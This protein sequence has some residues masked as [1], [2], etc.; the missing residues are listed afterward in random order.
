MVK[1]TLLPAAIA[2]LALSAHAGEI[3]IHQW[4]V[5][6][7]PQEVTDIPVLMDVGFFVEIKNQDKLRIKLQQVTIRD[8]EGCTEMVVNTNFNLTLSCSIYPTGAVSGDY[9][10]TVNPANLDAPGGTTIVCAQLKNA[11]FLGVSGGTKDV[12]VATV[13]VLVVPR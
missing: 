11:D 3:K 1:R 9:S 10:C 12:Q 4:P 6:Y 7:I 2:L 5:A 13:K 8:Y